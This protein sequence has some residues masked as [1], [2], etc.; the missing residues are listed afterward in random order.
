MRAWGWLPV[1]GPA[2]ACV[3]FLIDVLRA[4]FDAGLCSMKVKWGS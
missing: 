2:R 4:V 1:G 3:I